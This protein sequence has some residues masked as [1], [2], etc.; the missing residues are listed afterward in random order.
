M[1]N[2]VTDGLKGVYK[3]K[4][5]WGSGDSTIH[6]DK[7]RFGDVACGVELGWE[8]FE[9]CHFAICHFFAVAVIV[10]NASELFPW[11]IM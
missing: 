4:L 10:G 6:E 11:V 2:W 9:S 3:F 1:S 7:E 5:E 8:G